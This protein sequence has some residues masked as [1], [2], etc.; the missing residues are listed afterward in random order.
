MSP[1]LGLDFINSPISALSI[2]TF[3]RASAASYFDSA[4]A[5][6]TALTNAAR[7]DYNPATLAPLGLLIEEARTNLLLN[8]ATLATQDV[9]VSA[10][11]YTLSF[12]GTGTVTLSGASTAGPLV[13]SGAFPTRSTLTFTPSAATL[14]LTV[15]GTVQYANLEAGS[16]ATSW[17]STAG[18]TATRAADVCSILTSAFPFNASEGTFLVQFSPIATLSADAFQLRLDDGTEDNRMFFRANSGTSQRFTVITATVEVADLVLG[19]LS[20]TTRRTMAARYKLNDIAGQ[21]DGQTLKTDT[22]AAIS[23]FTTMRIGGGLGNTYA[24]SHLQRIVYWPRA[25]SNGQIG[26]AVA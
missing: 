19:N 11:P 9:A 6:Q 16:F 18:A 14:T 21:I 8:S 23:V 24:N 4:G 3:T 1:G 5:I 22:A 10:V 13:G 2:L 12:Y 26:A 17:I 7:I 25:L 15:T 20:G